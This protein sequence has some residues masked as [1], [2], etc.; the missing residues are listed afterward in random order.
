MG[1]AEQSQR[2]RDP[3]EHFVNL[4]GGEFG[5]TGVG[6]MGLVSLIGDGLRAVIRF[7]RR[8]VARLRG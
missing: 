8:M 7:V 4:P 2:Y 6:S 3:N 1:D 5:G